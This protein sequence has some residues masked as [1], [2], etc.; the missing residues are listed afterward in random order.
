MHKHA[1]IRTH[2]YSYAWLHRVMATSSMQMKKIIL[3]N[4]TAITKL[5]SYTQFL[6]QANLKG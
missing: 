4:A 6:S 1:L 3:Y 2:N 5:A